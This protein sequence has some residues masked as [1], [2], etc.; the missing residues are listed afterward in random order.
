M[1]QALTN[2][3]NWSQPHQFEGI[4][5]TIIETIVKCARFHGQVEEHGPIELYHLPA[6]NLIQLP[7][8]SD[9]EIVKQL[10]T[11]D[12]LKIN[13]NWPA[14]CEGSFDMLKAS[15]EYVGS[16]GVYLKIGDANL[17]LVSWA[18]ALPFGSIHA[19]HTV[20]NH[21]RKGYAT[22]TMTAVSQFLKRQDRIPIV[23]I[24]KTNDTSKSVNRKIGFVYSH[25]ISLLHYYPV[26]SK[27]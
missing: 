14:A 17:E 11:N 21:Q 8:H 27:E 24:Y 6:P 2:R 12:V 22:L 13:G 1:L 26:L 3:I 10:S 19:L 18:V 5:N 16:A 9:N 15:I 25:D 7:N 20:S 23:Q 4:E